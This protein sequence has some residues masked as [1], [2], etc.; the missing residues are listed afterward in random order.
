MLKAIA[1][2]LLLEIWL[3]IGLAHVLIYKLIHGQV[4]FLSWK[5]LIARPSP[6]MQRLYDINY[7]MESVWVRILKADWHPNA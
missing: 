5:I 3:G 1:V 4:I 6:G 7:G 2:Q